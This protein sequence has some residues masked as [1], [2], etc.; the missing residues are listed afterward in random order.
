MGVFSLD[1]IYFTTKI[2]IFHRFHNFKDGKREGEHQHLQ[3]VNWKNTG[4]TLDKYLPK[5]RVAQDTAA[6]A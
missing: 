1:V 5:G 4:W 2:N 3:R 6:G